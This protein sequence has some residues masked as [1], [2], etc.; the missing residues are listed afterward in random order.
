MIPIFHSDKE[1][2]MNDDQLMDHIKTMFQSTP[3]LF[4]STDPA[5]SEAA[6]KSI[7]GKTSNLERLIVDTIAT[8]GPMTTSEIQRVLERSG[9]I[10]GGTR[11]NK[12]MALLRRSNRIQSIGVRRD[13]VSGRV[14]TLYALI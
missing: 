10:G 12:R 13:E 7:E 11:I 8:E 5:T 6:A 2:A 1:Q 4:R 9:K 3:P 14:Q